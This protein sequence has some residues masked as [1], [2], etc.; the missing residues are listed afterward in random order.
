MTCEFAHHDGAYVLG[1]L[2]ATER[3]QYERHLPGCEECSDSV[4]E[5]AGLPGLLA[6]VPPNVLEPPGDP[7]QI[8]ETVFPAVLTEARRTRRRRTARTVALAAAVATVLIAGTV[9]V[10][11]LSA[12]NDP[13]TAAPPA[14]EI[15]T[16]PSQQMESLGSGWVTGWVSLTEVAWGTRIDLTCTY[17]TGLYGGST[18]YAL[19]VRTVDGHVEQAGTWRARPG[20][21]THISMA[22]A[23]AHDDIVVIEVRT[24]DGARLLRLTL[25]Q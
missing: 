20:R 3:A 6:R 9:A 16:A 4:R 5:L 25:A 1:A 17:G 8:P 21:A 24:P 10:V 7:E 11:T 15:T 12:R 14:S 18:S 13:P 23:A 2:D 22:T 19:F